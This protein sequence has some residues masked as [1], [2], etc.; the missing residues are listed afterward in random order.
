M[1]LHIMPKAEKNGFLD[2]NFF[3]LILILIWLVSFLHGP[4]FGMISPWPTSKAN[5][6]KN[7]L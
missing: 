1:N 7:K 4:F 6:E 5:D 3:N 2:L